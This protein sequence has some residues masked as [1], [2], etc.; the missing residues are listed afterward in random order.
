MRMGQRVP[1]RNQ[2]K[3]LWITC[4]NAS[5]ELQRTLQ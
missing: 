2:T 5:I 4:F 1:I 3:D